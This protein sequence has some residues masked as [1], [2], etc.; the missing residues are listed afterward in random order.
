M[1]IL[2]Q[3]P[4][5]DM[6]LPGQAK[7]KS[8]RGGDSAAGAAVADGICGD[9]SS[10]N[11]DIGAMYLRNFFLISIYI[12]VY[13]LNKNRIHTDISKGRLDSKLLVINRILNRR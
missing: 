3:S 11:A 2:D 4:S 13:K 5:D 8:Q 6:P 1:R 12:L 9:R 7:N 10:S